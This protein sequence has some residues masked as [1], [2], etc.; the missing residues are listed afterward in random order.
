M[1]F[2]HLLSD[3]FQGNLIRLGAAGHMPDAEAIPGFGVEK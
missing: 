3:S 2:M 1:P